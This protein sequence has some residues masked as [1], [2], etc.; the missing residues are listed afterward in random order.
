MWAEETM[1]D[2]FDAGLKGDKFTLISLMNSKCQ[3]K[4]KTPVG[5]IDRFELN[6]IEMQGTVLSRFVC[7]TTFRNDRRHGRNCKLPE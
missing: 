1:N 4:V 2:A 3:V 5:G 7:S 6:K